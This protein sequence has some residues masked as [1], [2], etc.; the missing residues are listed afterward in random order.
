LYLCDRFG[1]LEL[2]YRDERISSAYPIPIRPRPRPPMRTTEV[3]WDGVQEGSLVVQ[4]IYQGLTGIA[5]GAVKRLRI[6]AVPPKV[7]PH[8]NQPSI[9]VSAEDPGKYVLGTV[10]VA[11]DGSAFFRIP[12]GIP[13]FFQAL[14]DKGL[15]LQ[16]MRSLTYVLPGQTLSCVGCHESRDQAA[17]VGRMPLAVQKGP[18]K[19]TPGPDGSWPLRFDRLVQPVLDRRCIECHNPDAGDVKAA[20]LDLTARNA[21]R[22]LI[23]FAGKDLEK[24]A[25]EKDRSEVGRGPAR[26]SRLLALL[27]QD[28]THR[29]IVLDRD[30]LE[31]L[32]TWMDTY[33]HRQGHFS[34]EQETELLAFKERYR[35]L[36]E[37]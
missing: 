27:S 5:P 16:T 18:S 11:L 26:D 9:G 25:F 29:Q 31:R 19:L 37:Y 22:N 13:V 24:L 2:L 10:P 3:D 33:A 14:D 34:P 20:R 23:S 15:A 1:N 36:L 21:Y 17:P 35:H 7:Q 8:M 30:S 32:A 28:P 4:D 12:S 6:V